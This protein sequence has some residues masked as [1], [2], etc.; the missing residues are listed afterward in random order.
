M[1]LPI[2]IMTERHWDVDAKAALGK[3]LPSLVS[4]GYN[5]LCF[6][7]PS[8]EGEVELISSVKSTIKFIQDRYAE[9][10]DMLQRRGISVPDLSE[11][12]YSELA[13]FLLHFVSSRH[14]NEMAIW[15]KELP[16]HV[17]KLKMLE[18]AK[19]LNMDIRGID[20]VN[21]ELEPLH[22]S[23]A[24][25]NL[26][27]KISA[28]DL[29]DDKRIASFKSH[30]LDLQQKGKGVIFVVG[31]AHYERLVQ[32]F[33]KE[34]CLTDVIF[35][36]PYS[37]K[38]FDNS[39]DDRRLES[40]GDNA[41]LTLIEQ[42]IEN[43]ADIDAFAVLL[44]RAIQLKVDGYQPNEPTIISKKLHEKTGLFFN[45]YARPSMHVDAYYPITVEEDIRGTTKK[46]GDLG[47]HGFFTSFKGTC[48]YCIPCINSNAVGQALD[49]L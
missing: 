29:L 12:N 38:C 11:M 19:T 13:R 4:Q 10:Q 23:E 7:S 48:S 34:Y 39:V 24:Q 16:G 14:S 35:I 49:L 41:K 27:A 15:F 22:C 8:D 40:I 42:Q 9:A 1:M 20:L 3:T 21:A 32:A 36:H 18:I 44:N 6:E 47:V 26:Q 2:I 37:P 28:I 45:I 43:Q 46:L 33:S 17:Q 25:A 5:L 30:V 31:Q